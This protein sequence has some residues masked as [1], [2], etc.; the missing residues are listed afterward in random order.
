MRSTI[1][2][3]FHFLFLATP[4]FFLF[5]TDE[6]FEFNKMMLVYGVTLL[7]STA[8]VGR[9]IVQRAVI[10]VRTPFDWPLV[11]FF[12]SQ[13]I[14]T[15]FSIHPYTSFFG[16]YSRFH[17]GLLSTICYL[18]LYWAFVSTVRKSE[19]KSF[20]ISMFG[21]AFLV[22]LYA[23]ME[24]YGHSVSCLL[25][26]GGQNFG[27]DCWIQDV[28]SRV[29][30]TFGQ[31]NWLAAYLIMLLPMSLILSATSKQSTRWVY[32]GLS[33]L[34]LLTLFFTQSRSG[35]LGFGVGMGVLLGGAALAVILKTK[36][37]LSKPARAL[38]SSSVLRHLS[39]LSMGVIT[40]ATIWGPFR[41]VWSNLIP[42]NQST[43][44]EITA[45]DTAPV[46][47]LDVG[48]TDSGEIRKIVWS[49]AV[50]VFQ[51]YPIFGSGVDTFAYSYYLDR[52]MAHNLVSEWDFL[53]NR[54]HNEFLN[55]LATTGI[56]GLLSYCGMLVWFGVWSVKLLIKRQPG[57]DTSEKKLLTVGLLSGMIGL[58]ISNFFGFSTV[59]VGVMLFLWFALL[60]VMWDLGKPNQDD[61][62]AME[63]RPVRRPADE[64]DWSWL[65]GGF[66]IIIALVV[67]VKWYG[68]WTADMLYI[69]GKSLFAVG[70]YQEGLDHLTQ[71]I[72][73]SPSEALFYDELAMDYAQL[74]V[75]MNDTD[76]TAAATLGQ[77]AIDA[78]DKAI[79]LN[80]A[81]LN[82]YKT[83][84]RVFIT[85]T[86]IDSTMLQ[87]S[88]QA[89]QVALSLAPTDAKLM[90][91][92]GIVQLGLEN[93][94][95]GIEWLQKAVQ[96][97][98]DYAAARIQLGDAYL[99]ALQPE[100]AKTEYQ[101]ILEHIAPNDPRAAA[102]LASVEAQLKTI[103]P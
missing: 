31:P 79:Q 20:F 3:L 46:N 30:A 15:I 56:V 9:M 29:F 50:A 67:G 100:K 5:T 69:K 101:Y 70:R 39:L 64:W 75:A 96:A 51:R 7:I 54:A 32:A 97:K 84:S 18:I 63:K 22:S 94:V 41:P 49:G 34:F 40:V 52:P 4:L 57:E 87:Y 13:V 33:F 93:P 74:A 17:G 6:L 91:N 72:Q 48:G 89:L 44:V 77:A 71:A 42:A 2:A 1:V 36:E 102:S 26:S 23:V 61:A 78:S 73:L 58:S 80:S 98:P 35:I 83:R 66:I 14:S 59:M 38:T 16:Y 8:W 43:P 68:Y 45:K 21:A 85:L 92:L 19:I 53:Y 12:G 99:A 10:L 86:Q 11:A 76:A 88:A 47:R 25:I 28:Q 60:T 27:V 37:G 24:H 82:F 90:Y 55:I 103:E 65:A 95:S 62:Q 81:H